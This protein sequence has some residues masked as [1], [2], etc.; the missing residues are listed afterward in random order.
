[1]TAL[2]ERGPIQ[3]SQLT[4]TTGEPIH[5][6]II[7]R[8][9]LE[10]SLSDS[11]DARIVNSRATSLFLDPNSRLYAP[12]S[13]VSA[14]ALLVE[15]I[16]GNPDHIR[17]LLDLATDGVH[18]IALY[19]KDHGMGPDDVIDSTDPKSIRHMYEIRD[20]LGFP[21]IG[22]G[23]N[24]NNGLS[25]LRA[26]DRTDPNRDEF[27]R[28][29]IHAYV[30]VHDGESDEI[31]GE[32]LPGS[33]FGLVIPVRLSDGSWEDLRIN[34]AF[35][36]MSGELP[37]DLITGGGY[38]QYCLD[39]IPGGDV[40]RFT[41]MHGVEGVSIGPTTRYLGD[42][43][44]IG[45]RADI[46]VR[47]IGLNADE[48]RRDYGEVID[49]DGI[50]RDGLEIN[51]QRIIDIGGA[52]ERLIQDDTIR[53]WDRSDPHS[54]NRMTFL[55]TDGAN[56]LIIVRRDPENAFV[57]VTYAEPI[58][59]DIARRIE[60]EIDQAT[61]N[62]DHTNGAG[63]AARAAADYIDTTDTPR[64]RQ[65]L[66]DSR[67]RLAYLAAFASLDA[68]IVCRIPGSTLLEVVKTNPDAL[69]RLEEQALG[70]FVSLKWISTRAGDY[71]VDVVDS[72]IGR[73]AHFIVGV[74]GS[75]L[76]PQSAKDSNEALRE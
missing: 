29:D 74:E 31:F 69:R 22:F 16:E 67:D 51:E 4:S 7:G 15:G 32:Q 65:Q 37:E 39:H 10:P 49:L 34:T 76:V 26:L 1:M 41:P 63:D 25:D 72:P 68:G 46:P 40:S 38:Q 24:E 35:V 13:K 30:G 27:G 28:L 70:D 47:R 56:G 36:D 11:R 23:G 66:S 62:P 60:E 71:A 9:V 18:E 57:T 75:D 48:F 14:R 12:T 53:F 59:Q 45:R 61:I 54:L 33:R 17:V 64:L 50:F 21:R 8:S 20:R 58:N 5:I 52:V 55:I 3:K 42:A 6:G 73:I 44:V 2:A 19:L 43:V